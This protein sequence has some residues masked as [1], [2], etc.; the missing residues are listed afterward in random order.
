MLSRYCDCFRFTEYCKDMCHCKNCSNLEHKEDE[1]QAAIAAILER[2]PDAFKYARTHASELTPAVQTVN[3][4]VLTAHRV[5]AIVLLLIQYQ[6]GVWYSVFVYFTGISLFYLPMFQ[7][8]G[9][10]CYCVPQAPSAGG[11]FVQLQGSPDWLPLPQE[12]LPQKVLRVLH[13]TY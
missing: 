2:N 5:I 6:M 12:F 13:G 7:L 11:S 9:F 4:A 3:T 1:R 8:P 10:I